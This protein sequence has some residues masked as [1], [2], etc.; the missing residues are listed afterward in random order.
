MLGGGGSIIL[1]SAIDTGVMLCKQVLS[2]NIILTKSYSVTI[3]MKLPLQYFHML[4]LFYSRSSPSGHSCKQTALLM[5]TFTKPHFSQLNTNSV[6]L[7]SHKRPAP[8]MDIFFCEGVCSRE[9]S[10]HYAII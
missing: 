1:T 10:L 9:L 5:A 4:L 2:I 8:V 6:F 3:H 7:H